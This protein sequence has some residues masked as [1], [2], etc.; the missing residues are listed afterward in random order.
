MIWGSNRLARMA[1][2]TVIGVLVA[3]LT[4]EAMTFV[5]EAKVGFWPVWFLDCIACSSPGLSLPY[6][7]V[8]IGGVSVPMV[9]AG[10]IALIVLTR[11]RGAH[12]W[13]YGA[14]GIATAVHAAGTWAIRYPG[15]WPPVI[16]A[17]LPPAV[18]AIMFAMA[19][20]GE[21]QNVHSSPWVH[22]PMD[23]I[24][25]WG[26]VMAGIGAM[27]LLGGIAS[28]IVIA[29]GHMVLARSHSRRT[30]TIT[31][32]ILGYLSLVARVMLHLRFPG[33]IGWL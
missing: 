28:L 24:R 33:Q 5:L 10:A 9:V 29:A 19:A 7:P 23:A 27:V 6:G 25:G 21:E 8:A 1:A 31:G 26:M 16:V 14:A 20:V 17:V 18:A 32:L 13:L 22:T 15:S 4:G 11:R 12:R 30:L 2:W 3:H